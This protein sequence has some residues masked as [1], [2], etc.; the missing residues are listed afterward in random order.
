MEENKRIRWWQEARFGMFVHWGLYSILG[1]GEWVLLVERI[2][3]KEYAK[4]ADR[5]IPPKSFSPEQWVKLAKESGMKYIVLTTR[6]HD[7]FCLFDSKASNFTSVKTAAKRDFVEEYVDACRKHNIRVGLYY[8]L[9]DW[10]FPG[11]FDREKYPESFKDTVEQAHMQVKELM[12]NYG[13]IDI[14]WYDGGWLPGAEKETPILWRSKELNAM[15]RKLQPDIIINDRSG[16]P[17]D[18]DTP[19][20]HTT[21]SKRPWESCMTIGDSCGW[22]YI[23][24]NPNMKPTT[25][26]IQNLVSC[27]SNGGN[28]LLNIGPKPDGSVRREEL[29]RLKEIGKW[30][31]KNGEGIYGTERRPEGFGLW[32]AGMLGMATVKG[33]RAYLHIFRWPGNTAVITGIKNRVLSAKML[34]SGKR[35][36]VKKENGKVIIKGLPELPPD[37]YG[38]VIVLQLD[39]KPETFDYSRIPLI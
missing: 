22:G 30:L 32:G 27:A 25:Q 18:F 6:H 39:G 5:F 19:E 20:Q 26:L 2:P 28:Y 35:L 23:K 11:Y 13:K 36:K 24:H 10:R 14:L 12:S 33:N 1:R 3:L 17:E 16:L 4:L 15:V 37:K 38:T 34:A 9:L 31:L 21:P 8:S 7:G 29:I